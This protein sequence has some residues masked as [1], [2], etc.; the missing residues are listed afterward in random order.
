MALIADANLL[1][2]LPLHRLRLF[3]QRFN[4]AAL[5]AHA[6]SRESWKPV[7]ADFL[8]WRRTASQGGMSRTARIRNVRGALAVR[9]KWREQLRGARVLLLDD[10]QTTGATVEE[11]ARILKRSGASGVDVLTLA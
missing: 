7:A 8:R 3:A 6:L 5:L 4:Q 9:E 10:V 11:C 1:A 2:H